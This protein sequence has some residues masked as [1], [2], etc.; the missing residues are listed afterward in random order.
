MSFFFGTPTRR[1]DDV[2]HPDD[3]GSSSP[4]RST[5]S[6]V[7]PH[8]QAPSL[9][10]SLCGLGGLPQRGRGPRNLG[11]RSCVCVFCFLGR[12]L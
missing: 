7:A 6:A 12:K 1:V 11:A 10:P 2:E 9:A 4:R 8:R 5:G 3:E